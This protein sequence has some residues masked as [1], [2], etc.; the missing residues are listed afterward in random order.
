MKKMF[1]D[2]VFSAGQADYSIEIIDPATEEVI[3]EVPRGS[4]REVERA[5]VAAKAA[6]ATWQRTPGS[7]K[8]DYLHAAA[9]AIHQHSDELARLLTMEQGKPLPENEEE[10]EWTFNTLRY[11][12][13]MGRHDRGSLIPPGD[14][15]Q[16]NF[17][18][19]EAYGVVGC[20]VPWNFPLLLLVWKIAPALAAGNTVVI[21]PSEF[22]PLT[23]LKMVELAFQHFPPGVINV[24]T[25][26]GPETGEVLVRHPD[27]RMIAF[28]GSLATG[29]RIAQI[30][31]PMMKKVHLELGGKDPMVIGPDAPMDMAVSGLAY[32]ALYNA[33]QVCTSTERVYVHETMIGQFSEELSDFVSKLRL[34]SGLSEETDIGPMMRPHFRQKVVDHIAQARE[35]GAQVLTGGR[36]PADIARGYYFEP[37]V[38]V[39]VDHQMA[40]MRDETFGPAIPL[41]PYRDFDEA[42]ALANDTQFGLG[43]CL[44]S[45]DAR[46][47]KRFFEGVDAGTIWINDPLTDNYGGPFGGMKMTGGGRELGQAGFDEFTQIKHVHWDI[48]GGTKDYWYPY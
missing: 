34:G 22:T 1:I 38:L 10:V 17:V 39:N 4:A 40:I 21:K 13:E 44:M 24:V 36:I 7:E 26:Y 30:A 32:S 46:L 18:M 14:R 48:E 23:T 3:D 37:S 16:L 31:A 5:V 27:V 35:A 41:M 2:G 12:A 19:K 20:I 25:G 8:A 29:Q 42:I 9:N 28:T 15:G 33:G 47:V 11:Y 43:A 45:T 6:Y